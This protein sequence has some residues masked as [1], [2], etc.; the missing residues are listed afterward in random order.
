MDE[1]K[2]LLGADVASVFLV[3]SERQELYSN[4]NS[5]KGELRVPI[6]AGIAGHV[7]T[8]GEPLI[9]DDAYA[10]KRFNKMN[11]MKTGFRTRNMMCVPLKVKKGGVLGVVQLINK[12]DAGV[13]A[14]SHALAAI[15]EESPELPTQTTVA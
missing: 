7:A 6:T 14:Q 9:I 12:T 3:D 10:D 1:A 11:D 4:V 13:F 8:T 5:T 2:M 15:D